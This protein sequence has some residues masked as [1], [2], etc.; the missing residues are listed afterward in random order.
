MGSV[1]GQTF[2]EKGRVYQHGE[3][4]TC[5]VTVSESGLSCL[6][7]YGLLLTGPTCKRKGEGFMIAA[8]TGPWEGPETRYFTGQLS[9]GRGAGDGAQ[10]PQT[11]CFYRDL[12]HSFSININLPY[13]L[14][15]IFRAFKIC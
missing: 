7:V 8:V 4:R 14:R 1:R 12:V 2:S 13:S 5:G 15:T 3:I 10:K 9:W 11:R 6:S